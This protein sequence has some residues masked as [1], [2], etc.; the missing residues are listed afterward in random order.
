MLNY[1]A[2]SS[3]RLAYFSIQRKLALLLGK[4]HGFLVTELHPTIVLV[5]EVS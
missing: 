1:S 5:H 4:L 2:A 3:S